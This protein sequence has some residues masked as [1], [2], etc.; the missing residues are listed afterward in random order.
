MAKKL[1]PE[2]EHE[3]SQITTN[4]PEPLSD[5]AF[6]RNLSDKQDS[7]LHLSPELEAFF[8]KE[9]SHLLFGR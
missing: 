6:L 9:F 3:F 8:G 5:D 1:T 4:S 7:D 2:Q